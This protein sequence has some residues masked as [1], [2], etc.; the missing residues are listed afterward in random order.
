MLPAQVPSLPATVLRM[1]GMDSYKLCCCIWPAWVVWMKT[2]QSQM[3]ISKSKLRGPPY[4]S[5]VDTRNG[6]MAA[7]DPVAW[8]HCE[9]E[10]VQAPQPTERFRLGRKPTVTMTTQVKR[11]N[12]GR[13]HT[14]RTPGASRL[15]GCI[16][17]RLSEQSPAPPGQHTPRHGRLG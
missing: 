7:I 11:R 9:V 1:R 14:A 5:T 17:R 10:V 8:S 6:K 4:V 3:Q 16:H 13:G 12:A 2:A 15:G